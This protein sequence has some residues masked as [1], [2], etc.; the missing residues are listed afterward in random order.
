MMVTT[1]NKI[2]L[3][4]GLPCCCYRPILTPDFKYPNKTQ[5]IIESHKIIFET[6]N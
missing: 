5:T 6:H 3:N 1:D 2:I 4:N